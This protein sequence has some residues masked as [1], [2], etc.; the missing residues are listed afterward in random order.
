MWTVLNG[1]EEVP[2]MSWEWLQ[3]VLQLGFQVGRQIKN[4][5]PGPVQFDTHAIPVPMER[6]TTLLRKHRL[7]YE[8]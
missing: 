2:L 7:A 1:R 6:G 3:W 5:L 4:V 8:I